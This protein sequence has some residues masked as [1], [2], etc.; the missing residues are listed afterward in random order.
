M[1]CKF[2]SYFLLYTCVSE[3]NKILFPQC[4]LL[5]PVGVASEGEPGCAVPLHG[6][7]HPEGREGA[8]VARPD[9]HLRRSSCRH[10]GQTDPQSI[11]PGEQQHRIP[12]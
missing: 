6:L 12:I 4:C 3:A 9:R 7:Q 11:L 2:L 5:E 1:R 8:S 10:H